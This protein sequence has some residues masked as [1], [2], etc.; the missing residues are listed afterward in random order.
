[1]MIQWK[2]IRAHEPLKRLLTVLSLDVLVKASAVLLLPVYLRLMTQDEYGLFNYILSILYA[3]AMMLNL[4]LYIPQSKLYHDYTQPGERGKLITSIHVLLVGG[5]L[6]LILPVYFLGLDKSIQHLLFRNPIHYE[7][8]RFWILL[9]LLTSVF[10]YLLTN[11]FYTAERIDPIKRYSLFR[12]AGIHGVSIG[13]MCLFRS[14]DPIQIRLAAIGCTELVLLIAFYGHYIGKAVKRIDPALLIRCLRLALPVM[15]ASLFSIIINF[16]DKFFLEKHADYTVLSVYYL[17]VACASVIGLV[18]TSLQN[19]WLPLFFKEKDLMR[20]VG[21]TNRLLVR[22]IWVLAALS[23]ATI[24]A[25]AVGLASNL[26]PQRY[27]GVQAVLPL[28]LASQVISCLALLYSNYL[29]Y[30]ERTSIILWAGLAVSVT[31]M[32]LDLV[33]IPVWKIYGAAIT[34]LVSNTCY[35]AIY[36]F[37]AMHYKR[38]RLSN[39]ESAE[40][41]YQ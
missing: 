28:L 16:G 23:L 31:S 21:K 20:N 15:L 36:Y 19:V 33:L 40:R 37:L 5:L 38:K 3:V 7:R 11:F 29:V 18:S 2:M 39:D 27:D 10:S 12:V 8:Y 34:L 41:S 6:V 30:F 14:G 32:V 1:M 24:A 26:I 4:G 25:V 13:T 35:L 17:G 22:L 9:L